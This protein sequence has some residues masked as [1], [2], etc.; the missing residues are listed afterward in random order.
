MRVQAHARVWV[1]DENKGPNLMRSELPFE[2]SAVAVRRALVAGDSASVILSFWLSYRLLPYYRSYLKSG[3][4]HY[5][6][7]SE[8]AWFLLLIL[9]LWLTLQGRWGLYSRVRLSW[10]FVF[11][12]L[13]RVQAF[14]LAGLAVVIFS[15]KLEAVGR[16]IVFGF[17][18]FYCPAF[19]GTR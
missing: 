2:S 17:L 4:Y 9:P 1:L 14:G 15:L 3:S 11:L 18:I 16:L 8:Y 10:S 7:F 6:P 13:F 19:V 5:G 12:R